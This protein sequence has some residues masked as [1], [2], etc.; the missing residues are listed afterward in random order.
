MGLTKAQLQAKKDEGTAE[1]LVAFPHSKVPRRFLVKD[2]NTS[3]YLDGTPE[4]DPPQEGDCLGPFFQRVL[5]KGAG[6][7]SRYVVQDLTQK[8]VAFCWGTVTKLDDENRFR[9]YI[10]TTVAIR[11]RDRLEAFTT[12]GSAHSVN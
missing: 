9:M 5:A 8:N 7:A 6:L 10:K 11:A 12:Y 4:T 1:Y 2:K 3:Y